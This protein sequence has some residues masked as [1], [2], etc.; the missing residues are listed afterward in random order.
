MIL[1]ASGCHGPGTSDA[2]QSIQLQDTSYVY[3]DDYSTDFIYDFRYATNNNFLHQAVYPCSSCVLS[4]ETVKALIRAN[5]SAMKKGFQ[6]RL[7]DCYRPHDIQVKMWEI[8]PDRRYVA[9]PSGKGSAHN[10]GI[11]VDFTLQTLDGKMLEM[12]TDF[13]YFGEKAHHDYSNLP[14]SVLENR[15]ILK[16]I[17]ENAGFEALPTEWWHYT[18][19]SR[20]E[21]HPN[22][23]PLCR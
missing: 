11:A 12:G 8:L 18:L 10:R 14:D 9:D 3:L 21:Y 13:D 16:Q 4:F 2:R 5:E 17:M 6:I 22:N 7:F 1:L 20:Y 23:F 19:R 15:Q